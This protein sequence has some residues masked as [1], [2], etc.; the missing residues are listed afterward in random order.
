[1]EVGRNHPIDSPDKSSR[2][3]SEG[4]MSEGEREILITEGPILMDTQIASPL[5]EAVPEAKRPNNR[6]VYSDYPYIKH[7]DLFHKSGAPRNRMKEESIYSEEIP[8]CEETMGFHFVIDTIMEAAL[9]ASNACGVDVLPGRSLTNIEYADTQL[10][11]DLTP[12]QFKHY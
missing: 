1:M 5:A 8:D 3:V 6:R 4:E 2:V 11:L 12:W 9:P 7:K 10:F